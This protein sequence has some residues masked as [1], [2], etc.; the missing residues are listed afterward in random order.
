LLSGPELCVDDVSF[1]VGDQVVALR[2][3]HDLDLLN[4]DTAIVREVDERELELLVTLDRGGERRLPASYVAAGHL[5]HGYAITV[6]KSQGMT[7]DE[8]FVYTDA[9]VY[10]EAAYTALSRARQATHVYHVD[11]EPDIALAE[12]LGR[13]RQKT[14]AASQLGTDHAAEIAREVDV[15]IEL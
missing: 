10:R 11:D 3:R 2:N 1:A 8:A 15:C 12:L 4:G 5:A 7:V 13:S 14:V 6:H 9:S